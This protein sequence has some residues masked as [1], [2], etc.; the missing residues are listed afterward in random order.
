MRVL[1]LDTSLAFFIV[2]FWNYKYFWNFC[3]WHALVCSKSVILGGH[4]KVW[5]I[6]SRTW[7]YKGCTRDEEWRNQTAQ[8]REDG[9]TFGGMCYTICVGCRHGGLMV[10]ALVSGW[11][12]PGSR[13][14]LGHCIVLLHWARH[15]TFS[16]RLFT[17]VYKWVLVTCWGSLTES[18]DAKCCQTVGQLGL[19]DLLYYSCIILTI[20][21]E[22]QL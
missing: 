19:K 4:Q 14:W 8:E 13:H 11:N 9:E 18:W 15:C 10:S 1:L 21:R 3:L 6:T 5:V 16:V 2:L 20:V 17:Q 12:G 22:K 7:E